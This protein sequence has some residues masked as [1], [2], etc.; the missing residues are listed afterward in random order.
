MFQRLLLTFDC[1][2]FT[3]GAV[4]AFAKALALIAA[5]QLVGG[6]WAILQTAAWSQMFLEASQKHD[7]LTSFKIIFEPRNKCAFCK[8]I[9]AAQK[10]QR[11]NAPLLNLVA[12]LELGLP[13]R[14][15]G[16]QLMP[17]EGRQQWLLPDFI[18]P[19]SHIDDIIPPV[20]IR[21][22]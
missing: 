17:G 1:G 18:W 20:P 4:G 2:S 21:L 9:D 14:A 5:L 3:I 12:R 19:E 22:V 13:P 11:E 16:L 7:L 15:T 8:K 10:E 6:H